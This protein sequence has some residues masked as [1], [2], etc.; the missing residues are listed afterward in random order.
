MMGDGNRMVWPPVL[1]TS[2]CLSTSVTNRK[3][4][5][6]DTVITALVCTTRS[7]RVG[8]PVVTTDEVYLK[9][10]SYCPILAIILASHPMYFIR[11]SNSHSTRT[12]L[13]R[14][15]VIHTCYG[16]E[17]VSRDIGNWLGWSTMVLNVYISR[18]CGASGGKLRIQRDTDIN[19][20]LSDLIRWSYLAVAK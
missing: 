12:F 17:F 7:A 19:V 3:S 20:S 2:P 1:Y 11:A 8:A 16:I 15:A 18:L 13:S 5:T 4:G 14:T 9:Q 6:Q 10:S